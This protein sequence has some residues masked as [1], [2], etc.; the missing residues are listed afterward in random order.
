MTKRPIKYSECSKGWLLEI[1]TLCRVDVDHL[2]RAQSQK[3]NSPWPQK[4]F[5]CGI[6]LMIC[7]PRIV[8]S[9]QLFGFMTY[10]YG[11]R[12]S[13]YV[14]ANVTYFS[15]KFIENDANEKFL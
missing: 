5:L 3:L 1:V 7:Q 4:I 11:H 6:H 13:T 2:L 14:T 12:E 15:T 9:E 8:F 10:Y